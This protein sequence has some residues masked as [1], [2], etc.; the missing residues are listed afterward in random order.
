MEKGVSFKSYFFFVF[1]SNE[2]MKIQNNAK[3]R[4]RIFVLLDHEKNRTK[5]P[6]GINQLPLNR[7]M[8]YAHL[9]KVADANIR[10]M[11]RNLIGFQ[12]LY[13][14]KTI[15]IH[16]YFA[17]LYL[18]QIFIDFISNFFINLN[19]SQATCR[20]NLQFIGYQQ[21]T[22]NI[23]GWNFLSSLHFP[24]KI[25]ASLCELLSCPNVKYFLLTLLRF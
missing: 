13:S 18:N 16:L 14:D 21:H 11:Q 20:I 15:I 24:E 10:Y 17:A 9:F 5:C 7:L 12:R 6:E 22:F 4:K 2:T 8:H 1:F 19:P 3:Q 25:F 23:L